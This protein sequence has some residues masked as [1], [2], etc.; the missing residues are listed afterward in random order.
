ML[1]LVFV[2]GIVILFVGM[3]AFG[4]LVARL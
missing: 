1:D 4:R 3:G 2:V